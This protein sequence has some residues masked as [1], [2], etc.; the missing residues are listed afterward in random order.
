MIRQNS[1]FNAIVLVFV[2]SLVLLACDKSTFNSK[3]TLEFRSV[4]STDLV[5]GDLLD[6]R[7]RVLDKEGDISDT[8]FIRA[9]TN[10]CPNNAV[11]LFYQVPEVP[12]KNDLD[13]EIVMRFLIGVIGEFPVY[14]LNLCPGVDTVNFRFWIKDKAGN[15]SDTIGTAEP[16]LIRNS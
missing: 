1:I 5:Q 16:I 4:R 8:L 2:S 6:I 12:L 9:A 14:N 3:P 10:R 13:A 7:L 15:I 11:N